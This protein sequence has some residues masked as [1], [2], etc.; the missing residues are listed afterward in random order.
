ML[1][2]EMGM[3]N[4]QLGLVGTVFTWSYSLSMPFAGRIADVVPRERLVVASLLLWS[5]ATLGTGISRSVSSFLFWRAAMG[6]TESLFMPAALALIATVHAEATRSRALAIFAT[7]Q[8]AGIF[9]GGWYQRLDGR[10]SRLA[11]RLQPA[12]QD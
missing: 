6:I 2:R 1:T 7:A 11:C 9:A 5:L 4:V 3:S 10:S 12:F 8:F